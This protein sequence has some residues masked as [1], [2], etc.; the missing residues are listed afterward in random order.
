MF[1]IP[2][3]GRE[4]AF[5]LLTSTDGFFTQYGLTTTEQTNKRFLY[6]AKHECLWNGYIW[7]FATSQTLTALKNIA[8]SSDDKKYKDM[9]C[10]LLSQYARMHKRTTEDGRTISWIDEV[11]DPRNGDWSSRTILRDSGWSLIK[12]GY[13]RGKDYN[14]STFCDLVI[15]GLLGVDVKEGEISVNPLVP[16]SWNYFSLTGLKI[17]GKEYDIIY[18]DK[19]LTVTQK[20]S[21]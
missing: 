16:E 11:M 19:K 4:E 18:S 8:H 7:P 9:F 14:H 5:D 15:S 12:G 1:G 10:S 20:G 3:K 2:P 17:L 13:E 21:D 6:S